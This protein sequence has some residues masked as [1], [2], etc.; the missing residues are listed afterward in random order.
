VCAVLVRYQPEFFLG[1]EGIDG[2]YENSRAVASARACAQLRPIHKGSASP[3]FAPAVAERRPL[4]WVYLRRVVR[5]RAASAAPTTAWVGAMARA[6][7]PEVGRPTSAWVG[8]MACASRLDGG[9]AN[10]RALAAAGHQLTGGWMNGQSCLCRLDDD[11]PRRGR[12]AEWQAPQRHNEDTTKKGAVIDLLRTRLSSTCEVASLAPTVA[13]R[14]P[15]VL[16]APFDT[17][18][19]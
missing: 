10:Y 16:C 1:P 8:A 7:R 19:R 14:S 3:P 11:R 6:S 15:D 4:L 18:R 5:V 13:G 12:P 9:A 2:V 17:S